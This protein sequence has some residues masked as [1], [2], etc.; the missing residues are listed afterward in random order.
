MKK[1]LSIMIA[2]LFLATGSIN[3]LAQSPVTEK[4]VAGSY[5][6]YARSPQAWRFTVDSKTMA[7]A[8]VTGKYSATAG[9]PM[10]ID[11][12]V[13]NE[14]NYFKWRS[15]DDAVKAAAKPI[16]QAGRKAGGDV[17]VRLSEPGHYYVVLS[18]LFYYEGTRTVNAD[19]KLQFDKR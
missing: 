5:I 10:D 1:Y 12:L 7:N 18:N 11:F 4:L 19:L 16:F 8:S 6:V 2:V 9:T 14:E 13:L 17:N 15:E 3:L